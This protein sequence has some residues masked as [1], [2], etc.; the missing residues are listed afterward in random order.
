MVSLM[1][2]QGAV[3]G[4]MNGSRSHVKRDNIK[5]SYVLVVIF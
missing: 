3:G 2:P 1:V 4:I 5:R